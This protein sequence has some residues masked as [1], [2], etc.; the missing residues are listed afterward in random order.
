MPNCTIT[1]TINLTSR[2][3][4]LMVAKYKPIPKP[5][6][7]VNKI[8]KGAITICQWRDCPLIINNTTKIIRE[9][10]ITGDS[11][12]VSS[13]AAEVDCGRAEVFLDSLA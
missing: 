7:I 5:L 6:R 4:T 1:G 2:Y 10:K 12:D 3:F 9:I 13:C 11:T 8:N